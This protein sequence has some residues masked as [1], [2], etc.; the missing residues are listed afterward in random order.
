MAPPLLLLPPLG[1]TLPPRLRLRPRRGRGSSRSS[2]RSGSSSGSSSSG[3][4]GF[5]SSGGEEEDA[6]ED[7]G[8]EGYRKGGYHPVKP[9]DLFKSGRYS[10]VRKL[11]WGHFSTV[12]LVSDRETGRQGKEGRVFIQLFHFFFFFF[13]PNSPL[14]FS[15]FLPPPIASSHSGFEDSEICGSLCRG[16]EGR[17]RTFVPGRRGR[18]GRRAPLRSIARLVRAQGTQRRTRLYGLRGPGRQSPQLDQGL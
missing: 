13:S 17:G 14:S 16:C 11:G 5:S 3:A 2:S 1:A 4:E 9:G 6:S 15:L 18:P 10:V 7:E 8:T 12:W